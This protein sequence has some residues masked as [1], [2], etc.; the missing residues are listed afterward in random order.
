MVQAVDWKRDSL[1]LLDQRALPEKVEYVHCGNFREIAKAIRDMVV[2][3]APAIGIAG[4]YAMAMA[5]VEAM[6][7]V[8]FPQFLSQAAKH[9]VSQRPTAV[10]LSWAV[11]RVLGKAL[12]HFESEGPDG[13]A[14]AAER[15]AALVEQEDIGI[16]RAIGEHGAR[17][18]PQGARILTHCNAGALARYGNEIIPEDAAIL[19]HCNAGA[20]ATVGYGT[21]LGVVRQAWEDGKVAMV[22]ADETRPYLQ[23][24][25]LTAW[26]LLQDGIEVTLLV[27]SAAGYLMATGG[28]DLVVVGADRVARNGDVANKIGTYSLACLAKIHHVPFYVASPISTLDMSMGSGKEIP[29]EERPESEVLSFFGTRIA[30][31]G[32]RAF[33]PSFD[34]TPASLISGIITERGVVLPDI[35]LNLPNIIDAKT[36]IEEEGSR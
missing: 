18:V 36:D 7:S 14:S 27:D 3:G 10:N 25:R 6:D 23:G 22:Y 31:A 30:P 29:V 16:N 20:L 13:A 32:A 1:I 19:T 17:L 11:D 15:E 35:A 34:I 9:I 21:A 5:A 26:E 2:R 4:G 12:L 8:A 33:N 28:V 24:A